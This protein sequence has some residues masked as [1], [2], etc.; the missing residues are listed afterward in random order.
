MLVPIEGI[1]DVD[2]V[3]TQ[4]HVVLK[5]RL[6]VHRCANREFCAFFGTA[7]LDYGLLG[8]LHVAIHVLLAAA[9][10]HARHGQQSRSH[11]QNAS[12]HILFV[13]YGAVVFN[14]FAEYAIRVVQRAAHWQRRG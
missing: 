7:H 9:E 4:R 2:L 5:V 13:C 12:L 11:T 10:G 1:V 6:K 8:I 3:R 14:L